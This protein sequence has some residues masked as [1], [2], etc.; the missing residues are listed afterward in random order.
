MTTVSDASKSVREILT[1]HQ[2]PERFQLEY[3]FVVQGRSG[4]IMEVGEDDQP[5]IS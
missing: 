4:R 1:C 2:L 3:Q 5:Q